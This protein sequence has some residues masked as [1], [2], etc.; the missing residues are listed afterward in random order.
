[1]DDKKKLTFDVTETIRTLCENGVLV[2]DDEER[3]V[4]ELWRMVSEKNKPYM[5]GML[6]GI[7]SKV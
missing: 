2:K 7:T 4:L 5:L 6:N 3:Q 1:M